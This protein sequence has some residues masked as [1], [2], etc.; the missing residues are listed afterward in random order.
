MR[1][2]Y[3]PIDFPANSREKGRRELR[4]ILEKLRKLAKVL[5]NTKILGGYFSFK[6]LGRQ[7]KFENFKDEDDAEDAKFVLER[8]VNAMIVEAMREPS[9]S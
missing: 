2:I 8:L 9:D 5:E 4:P 6:F 7:Y 3:S 1:H